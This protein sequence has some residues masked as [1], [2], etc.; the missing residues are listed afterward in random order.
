MKEPI[1]IPY[2]Q[3]QLRICAGEDLG[4]MFL[5]NPTGSTIVRSLDADISINDVHSP[6]KRCLIKW[7]PAEGC[8]TL[9]V[10]PHVTKVAI[11]GALCDDDQLYTI[12]LGD[13]IQLSATVFVIE[14]AN[15]GKQDP[16]SL[17]IERSN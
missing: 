16:T 7:S 9:H 11:H 3:Y 15:L 2:A 10:R 5:I 17:D 4:K 12:K 14:E 1:V 13:I 8:Y 6:Q